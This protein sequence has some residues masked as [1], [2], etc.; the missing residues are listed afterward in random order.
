MRKQHRRKEIKDAYFLGDSLLVLQLFVIQ[1]FVPQK[2]SLNN[3][4]QKKCVSEKKK[5][6][7][8]KN[9]KIIFLNKIFSKKI[10]FRKKE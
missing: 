8:W 7:K 1:L 3:E 4:E 9:E 2:L 10:G 5:L 6:N